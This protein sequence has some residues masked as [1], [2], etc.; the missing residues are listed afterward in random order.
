[1]NKCL[2]SSSELVYP[3]A[4]VPSSSLPSLFSSCAHPLAAQVKS[5]FS[6]ISRPAFLFLEHVLGSGAC[7]HPFVV[8]HFPTQCFEL[9]V[10]AFA[11]RGVEIGVVGLAI[12]A[13]HFA[14]AMP[15]SSLLQ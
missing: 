5:F 2:V 12:G 1:M 15:L 7:Y 10:A 11:A 6:L 4:S 3:L 13:L 14:Q 9:D 8:V